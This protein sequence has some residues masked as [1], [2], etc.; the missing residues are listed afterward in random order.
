VPIQGELSV[1]PENGGRVSH[2]PTK[3]R[4]H[5]SPFGRVS[6]CPFRHKEGGQAGR[7]LRCAFGSSIE[8]YFPLH[9]KTAGKTNS[10]KQHYT[11][12]I[13]IEKIREMKINIE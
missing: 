6:T 7:V 10:E 5:S 2:S 12:M 4:R 13:K 8:S 3:E 11:G 1:P 9:Q